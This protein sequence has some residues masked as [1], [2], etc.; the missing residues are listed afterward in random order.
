MN[1]RNESQLL[2]LAKREVLQALVRAARADLG[3]NSV[4]FAEVYAWLSRQDQ[5]HGSQ[6]A[7]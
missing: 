3:S 5:P 4:A 7:R 1:D 2:D 6:P